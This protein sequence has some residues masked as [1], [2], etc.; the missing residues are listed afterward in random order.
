MNEKPWLEIE[1]A[2]S[3]EAGKH[4]TLYPTGTQSSL[5]KKLKSI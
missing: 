1:I 3:D 4:V 2:Y 5:A